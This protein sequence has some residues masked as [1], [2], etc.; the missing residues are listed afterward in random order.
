MVEVNFIYLY[1]LSWR[2]L[3]NCWHFNSWHFCVMMSEVGTQCFIIH[4]KNK[5]HS[6][7]AGI[8]FRRAAQLEKCV[9]NI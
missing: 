7:Y 8:C 2:L 9:I 5:S 1:I 3:N 6:H 4:N